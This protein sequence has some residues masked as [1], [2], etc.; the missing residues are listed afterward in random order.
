MTPLGANLFWRSPFTV[1]LRK[2]FSILHKFLAVLNVLFSQICAK[3]ML[4]FWVINQCHK[5]LNYCKF[6]K[7]FGYNL[8]DIVKLEGNTR[9]MHGKNITLISF[10]SRL[11]IFC[12]DDRQTYLSFFINVWMIDFCLEVYLWRFKRIFSWEIYF[13]PECS[14][15]VRWII[16]KEEIII[17]CI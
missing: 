17:N 9:L 6:K 5:S 8:V 15:I 1:F 4:W 2:F 7:G 11:P 14:F 12:T 13:N 10:G 16:L 3:R